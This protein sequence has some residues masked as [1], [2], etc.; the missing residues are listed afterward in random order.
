MELN[1]LKNPFIIIGVI[2]YIIYKLHNEIRFSR[3]VKLLK[4]IYRLMY[5]EK[6]PC[7]FLYVKSNQNNAEYYNMSWDISSR[8]NIFPDVNNFPEFD[9]KKINDVSAHFNDI[10]EN[11]FFTHDQ[12]LLLCDV[13]KE[14]IINKK[15]K[16]KNLKDDFSKEMDIHQIRNSFD[17]RHILNNSHTL[18]EYYILPPSKS[19]ILRLLIYL[20]KELYISN[21]Y[22]IRL[23]PKALNVLNIPTELS[24]EKK[25]FNDIIKNVFGI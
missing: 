4:C 15:T 5:F 10:I 23:E 16:I 18:D 25:S 8:E 9:L 22:Q 19:E 6:K 11:K 1:L 13:F 12:F 7:G 24:G 21:E 17:Y 2:S 3:A 14:K 20:K